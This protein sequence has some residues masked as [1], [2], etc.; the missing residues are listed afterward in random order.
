MKPYK[1]AKKL[2]ISTS[3]KIVYRGHANT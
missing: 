2:I 1:M 3:G